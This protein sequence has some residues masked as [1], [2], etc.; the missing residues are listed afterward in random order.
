VHRNEVAGGSLVAGA[1]RHKLKPRARSEGM[2][3]RRGVWQVATTPPDRYA[4]GMGVPKALTVV[5][6]VCLWQV[7]RRSGADGIPAAPDG[8]GDV[9]RRVPDDLRRNAGG[10]PAG[11]RS[12][13][14]HA[15][16]RSSPGTESRPV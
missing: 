6:G 10:A 3:T 15:I 4:L 14:P 16:R 7:K 9:G 1:E 13:R 11:A 5:C 8:R 2:P 12:R